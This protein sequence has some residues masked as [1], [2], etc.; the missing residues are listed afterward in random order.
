L[1]FGKDNAYEFPKTTISNQISTAIN[2]YIYQQISVQNL[3]SVSE[4]YDIFKPQLDDINSKIDS[5][6]ESYFSFIGG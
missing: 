1:N 3:S 4:V 5:L 2:D 6:R